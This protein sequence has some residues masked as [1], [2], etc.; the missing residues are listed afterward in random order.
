MEHST[1]RNR[2]AETMT[3]RDIREATVGEPVPV[4]GQITVVP[5]TQPGRRYTPGKKRASAPRSAIA[6]CNWITSVQLPC[7][8][9]RRNRS[10]TFNSSSKIPATNPRMPAP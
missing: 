4:N 8:V 6:S 10:S 5:T 1:S 3:E 7:R 2:P 9:S